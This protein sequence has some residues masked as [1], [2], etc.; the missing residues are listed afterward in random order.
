ML[1]LLRLE[2]SGQYDLIVL[3]TPPTAHALDFLEAPRRIADAI[4]SPALQW[5]APTTRPRPASRPGNGCVRGPPWCCSGWAS[6]W[7]AASWTISAPS[8]RF[9]AVLG[10]FLARAQPSKRCCDGPTSAS[11]WCWRRRSP[12]VNEALYFLLAPASGRHSPGRVHR[13]PRA[14]AARCLR[15]DR[16]APRLGD[17]PALIDVPP[18]TLAEAARDLAGVAHYMKNLS[19]AQHREITRLENTRRRDRHHHRAP[20][21]IR[22]LQLRFL[23]QRGRPPGPKRLSMPRL[24]LAFDAPTAVRAAVGALRQDLPGVRWTK[25][26]QHHVTLRFLGEIPG[27]TIPALQDA[28]STVRAPAFEIQATGLGTFPRRPSARHPAQVLFAALVP[29]TPLVDLKQA[30]DAALDPVLGP[31]LE[32][33]QRGF[34]PH[35]T[36]ARFRSDPGAALTSYLQ[37]NAGFSSDVWPVTEFSLY[38]SALGPEGARHTA[39]GP[40]AADAGPLIRA[41][42]TLVCFPSP[43]NTRGGSR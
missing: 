25:A 42:Q 17:V 35:L 37:A 34:S 10:G 18:A 27:E 41:P 33:A 3:D 13:Q 30:I 32:S 15:R 36:L 12:A 28:L 31:D 16:P 26:D 8:C 39:T 5:F 14:D 23:G 21:V 2:R 19:D 9:S 7:A 11:C 4:A 43:L 24:F 1:A 40:L 22:R 20:L 38:A 29:L 6:W